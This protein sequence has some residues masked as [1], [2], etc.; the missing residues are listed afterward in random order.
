MPKPR[1][2]TGSIL[3][4]TALL[5]ALV[6]LPLLG[7]LTNS[8]RL[9]LIR[10]GVHTAAEAACEDAA[11]SAADRRTF[12]D[13]GTLTFLPRW[14][15]QSLAQSTYAATRPPQDTLQYV[16]ALAVV[17]DY[18]ARV[19]RCTARVDVFWLFLPGRTRFALHVASR[20]RTR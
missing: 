16:T 5:F 1:P 13:T 10:Q 14:Q 11:W 4:W 3:A 8:A 9:Y 20:I 2:E 12:R 18:A 6:V 19:V 17:P 7:L 15:V